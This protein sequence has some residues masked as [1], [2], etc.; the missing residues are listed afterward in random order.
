MVC[1]D[2]TSGRNGQKTETDSI[3]NRMNSKCRALTYSMI[4]AFVIV[5]L[6]DSGISQAQ[7]PERDRQSKDSKTP[8]DP[9]RKQPRNAEGKGQAKKK[10]QPKG[11]NGA[12]QGP[13]HRFEIEPPVRDFDIILGRPTDASVTV[14]VMAQKPMDVFLRYSIAGNTEDHATPRK[15]LKPD[16]PAEW[17][18]DELTPDQEYKYELLVKQGDAADFEMRSAQSFR[19]ARKP[20]SAFAF[21]IQADSHLDQATRADV[22]MQTLEKIRSEKP[23][24]FVDLGDTFMTDKFPRHR[25]ALPQYLAQRYFLGQVARSSPLFLVLGNHDG[26]RGDRFDGTADSMPGWSNQLRKKLF[27]NPEPDRFYSGNSVATKPLGRL[28]NYYAWSWG[29]AQLI[30]LDPFWPTAQRTRGDAEADSNWSRTL[31]E[32]QY[33]WLKSTLETSKAKYK[34]VFIH[35]LVGGLDRSARGGAEAAQ[36]FEWGG[37]STDGTDDFVKRRPDWPM[38]IHDLLVKHKVSAVFHGH[39]HFYARQELDGIAYV[40]VP[41]PGHSGGGNA[42][43]SAEQ[44]GYETGVMKSSPGHMLVNVQPEAVTVE[45]VPTELPRNGNRQQAASKSGDKFTIVPK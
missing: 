14:S 42:E 32:E 33:R 28:Q 45:F 43:R 24:F 30:V 21:A 13:E 5:F 16:E 23:D 8:A 35:H 4:A 10:G 9:T 36:L 40:L 17:I 25:D 2:R 15:T 44:Y 11:K 18:L 1:D 7:V 22:Y 6:S 12:R 3:S 19:T 31:G 41:Q 34:F 29:D 37:K 27:P 20:G 26:E 38:P 39:D